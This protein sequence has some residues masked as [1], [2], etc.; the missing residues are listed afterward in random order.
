MTGDGSRWSAA[1]RPRA[2]DY[3]SQWA[4]LE[5]QGVD[6]HG[7]VAFV[8]E[9]A[10]AS[11]LDAGAGTG[12]VAI[13]LV[14][15]GVDAV[16]VDL[17]ESFVDAAREKAP[18]LEWHLADLA[19]VRLGRRFDVVVLAGNVMIFL[20]PGSEGAVL[21]NLRDHL[22]TGGRIV[23]GFQLRRGG[24]T[25]AG[26]DETAAAVGLSVSER[27]ATWSRDPYAGGDYAVSVL[28]PT[29]G[30]SVDVLR[31]RPPVSMDVQLP[32]PVPDVHRTSGHAANRPSDESSAPTQP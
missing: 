27:W 4:E 14:R 6:P 3:D 9:Y 23:A 20:A 17:D 31:A 13:E 32:N 22:A 29:P 16:G 28:T 15:R 1:A 26:L 30:W 10:P 5:A 25:L 24:L 11:V 21:A 2:T 19:T 12:R 18:E 7:E 8:M